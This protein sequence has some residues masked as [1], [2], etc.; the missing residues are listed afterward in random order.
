MGESENKNKLL[1]SLRFVDAIGIVVGSMIGS[2]IFLK[3]SGIAQVITS[4][5]LI[6]IVW[7]TSGLLTL[8][9]ALVIA[10]L[11]AMIPEPGGLYVYLHRAYGPFVG[12]VFGWSLLAVLQ[13]GSIAGLAA[14][15]VQTLQALF[16]DIKPYS[17][18][19]AAALIALL[20]IVNIVS[21]VG[22]AQ[23][24]NILTLAKVSGIGLL[25]A[26]AA[27]LEGGSAENLAAVEPVALNIGLL[28]AIGLCITK[29]LWAY[30]GWIN[31]SFVAGEVQEPQ[32]NIPKAVGVGIAIVVSIY[33]ATNAAYHYVLPLEMVA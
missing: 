10:E 29:A 25:V 4:P 32:R 11:G 26:G 16:P 19:F 5:A 3:A 31:L 9:G 20:T 33:L 6:L 15:S 12:F 2:G 18:L 8:A 23:V 24:Q 28:G 7:L 1:R 22:G 21:T 30:D 13:T 17:F 27:F 14:G